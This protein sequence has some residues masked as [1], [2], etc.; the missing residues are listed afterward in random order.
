MLSCRKGASWCFISTQE[1]IGLRG[2][3][4]NKREDKWVVRKESCFYSQKYLSVCLAGSHRQN[5]SPWQSCI[6]DSCI[7]GEW[8]KTMDKGLNCFGVFFKGSNRRTR[9]SHYSCSIP[10]RHVRPY[11][12]AN[13]ERENSHQC[14]SV[15]LSRWS[16]INIFNH[17]LLH[18]ESML[19]SESDWR[20]CWL[21]FF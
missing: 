9:W 16:A 17:W 20:H 13:G 21:I 8:E 4:G 2:W 12:C 11:S 5:R 6:R 18:T 19:A 7:H 15:H 3:C 10:R 1:Q 14:V